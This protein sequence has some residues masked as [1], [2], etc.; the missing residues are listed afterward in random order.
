MLKSPQPFSVLNY[1]LKD[2]NI[3]AHKQF[4]MST[5]NI[6]KMYNQHQAKL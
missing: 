6:Y 3:N 2:E 5:S 4:A 1:K